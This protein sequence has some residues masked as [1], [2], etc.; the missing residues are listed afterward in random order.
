MKISTWVFVAFLAFALIVD[1]VVAFRGERAAI[2]AEDM[3]RARAE[4][5]SRK[6]SGD[7]IVHSPLFS[8]RELAAL[9][10][11]PAKP[12]LP[13][14]EVRETR[15]ILVIDYAPHP[16]FGFG[17]AKETIPIGR[18]LE[19]R[20][21][22][23]TREGNLIL[24]DLY[25][26]LER[27]E[28]RIER[29]RGNVTSR[30]TAARSEGGR[31]CPG[32]AEW[33]YL[34]QRQLTIEGKSMNCV[35]SHPTNG[36]EIVVTLPAFP[37]PPADRKLMLEVSGAMTDDAVNQTADGAPVKTE[38]EQDGRT[39]GSLTAPNRVGW[40]RAQVAISPGKTVDLRTTT[41]KDGRRHYCINALVSEVSVH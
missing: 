41:L 20:I 19:L 26:D 37:E 6:K 23:P 11:L 2:P 24:F 32:E 29:P 35:W 39:I 22:E 28:Q 31:S 8:M 25:S 38:I 14:R 5:L 17:S 18:D 27:A 30:C 15:R 10:D 16:M 34:A 40:T 33:L 1:A 12:D 21:F 9:G 3:A 7:L 13:V 36:G 4:V